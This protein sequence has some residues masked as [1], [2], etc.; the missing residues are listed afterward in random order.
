MRSAFLADT[1]S[2]G[3]AGSDVVVDFRAALRVRVRLGKRRQRENEKSQRRSASAASHDGLRRDQ[4]LV[5]EVQGVQE[6]GGRHAARPNCGIRECDAGTAQKGA[7]EHVHPGGQAVGGRRGTVRA[8]PV[9][10]VPWQPP[11]S[12]LWACQSFGTPEPYFGGCGTL[13]NT[14]STGGKCPGCSHQWKWTSCPHCHDWSLH[15]DWYE[16]IASLLAALG[17]RDHLIEL[18][19]NNRRWAAERIASDPRSSQPSLAAAGAAP[20]CGSAA[21]TAAFRRTRSSGSLPGELFVHR[22]VA[23][24]VVHTD[25]NCLSVHA[26]RRR[27]AARASTSSSAAT[28]AAAAC[29]PRTTA[30]SWASST[31]GCGTCRTSGTKHSGLLQAA[32]R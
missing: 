3:Y 32:Q 9:S 19:D 15:E 23:N 5:Q 4:S 16:E 6:R 28:T 18:F 22:N 2:N 7:V 14:F 12:T 27:R 31:T 24:V 26:V 1:S 10:A 25:L 30:R 8:H 17:A 13:W 20:I 11:E 29:G 21:P